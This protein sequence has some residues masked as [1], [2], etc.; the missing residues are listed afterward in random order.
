M[1]A[2]G[3]G[4]I[5]AILV[6]GMLCGAALGDRTFDIKVHQGKK[7]KAMT[8]W[9]KEFSGPAGFRIKGVEVYR[10]NASGGSDNVTDDWTPSVETTERGDLNVVMEPDTPVPYC[11]WLIFRVKTNAT[12][13]ANTTT[14]PTV[15][16]EAASIRPMAL[17][18][19]WTAH[20]S[21]AERR[22]HTSRSW[23]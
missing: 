11:T 10:R 5:C 3:L 23:E 2:M 17:P 9:S 16:S 18:A 20:V 12:T 8:Q 15:R 7:N 22:E 14:P 6:V 13:V 21:Q 4:T 19:R 1:K